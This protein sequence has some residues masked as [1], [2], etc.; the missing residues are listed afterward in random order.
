VADL[1]LGYLENR[2]AADAKHVGF[3]VPL[4]ADTG[5]AERFATDVP[6]GLAGLEPLD[7]VS[8]GEQRL[9]PSRATVWKGLLCPFPVTAEDGTHHDL[10]VAY[11]WSFEEATS[12][13]EARERALTKAE[14]A[15]GRIRGGLGGRYYKTRKQLDT[16]VA[17]ILTG[18]VAGLITVTTG[19]RA[20]KPVITWRRDEDAIVAAATLD[21]PYGL[22]TNLPDPQG[23]RLD[24]L[25]VLRIYKDWWN[26]PS[27]PIRVRRRG[28]VAP[29]P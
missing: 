16:K 25:E 17:Q 2:C 13:A 24:A 3:V 12:V 19:T 1:G 18:R 8:F 20:G 7:Y 15:L 6:A 5:W 10:A 21:G 23:G 29:S 4:R 14:E 28:L 22:A 11:I 27:N 9:D 26:S